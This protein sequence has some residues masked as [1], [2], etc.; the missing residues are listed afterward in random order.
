[1]KKADKSAKAARTLELIISKLSENEIL[2]LNA[3]SYVRGGDA[4]DNGGE[5]II[6]IPKR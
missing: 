6:I 2:N 3:M 5:P 4:E 1:M